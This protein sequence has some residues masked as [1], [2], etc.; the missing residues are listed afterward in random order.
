MVVRKP[1]EAFEKIQVLKNEL[2]QGINSFNSKLEINEPTIKNL[3]TNFIEK[4][5]LNIRPNTIKE[6]IKFYNKWLKRTFRK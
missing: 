5:Q 2:R 6:Y 1:R 4:K 3:W